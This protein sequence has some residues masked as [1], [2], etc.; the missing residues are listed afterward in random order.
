M[1]LS[2]L[3]GFISYNL[4]VVLSLLA[5]NYDVKIHKSQ[6]N[7]LCIVCCITYFIIATF[8]CVMTNDFFPYKEIISI[9]HS[10]K[11]PFLS[12]EP[13]WIKTIRYFNLSHFQYIYLL[14]FTSFVEFYLI[15]RQLTPPNIIL[16]ISLWTILLFSSTIGGRSILFYMTFILGFTVFANRNYI[17]GTLL[18]F[19]SFFLHKTAYIA[20][21]LFILSLFSLNKNSLIKLLACAILFSA[22]LRATIF[23]NLDIIYESIA[24]VG[25]PGAIY[26]THEDNANATGM[27]LWRILPIISYWIVSIFAMYT[28]YKTVTCLRGNDYKLKKFYYLAFWSMTISIS[29][30]VLNLPDPAISSRVMTLST[31][32][33]IYLYSIHREYCKSTHLERILIFII[34]LVYFISNDIN[35]LRVMNI[36]NVFA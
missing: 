12:V 3:F 35:I 26:I 19:G 16:F 5:I 1:W 2:Y 34:L 7:A 9:I 25:I 20:V 32:P 6:R 15:L 27:Y 13:F 24:G 23:N 31:F 10:T 28:L 8:G 30:R 14:Q 17:I 11:D 33:V 18:L 36:N 4:L 29:L 21:P 22:I